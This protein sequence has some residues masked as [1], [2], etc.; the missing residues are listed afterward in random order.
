MHFV[1]LIAQ[2]FLFS[3]EYPSCYS[4]SIIGDAAFDPH[5]S[6]LPGMADQE[7]STIVS[8]PFADETYPWKPGTRLR[9]VLTADSL[10]FI[11]RSLLGT[12][13]VLLS[14]DGADLLGVQVSHVPM[15]NYNTSLWEFL[16][17][18]AAYGEIEARQILRHNELVLAVA[19]PR[20]VSALAIEY[21]DE[22]KYDGKR[23][24]IG[25]EPRGGP[26]MA[27][28]ESAYHLRKFMDQQ[29]SQIRMGRHE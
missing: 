20:R 9:L 5:R 18:L 7:L 6:S 4:H 2:Q 24:F 14:I 17:D 1:R 3:Q 26:G 16:S 22:T 11:K 25:I 8:Y 10:L 12:T 28:K 23:L 15:P 29:R 19:G 13:K 21:R 27:L